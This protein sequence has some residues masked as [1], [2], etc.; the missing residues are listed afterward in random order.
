MAFTAKRKR[1]ILLVGIISLILIGAAAAFYFFYIVP[2]NKEAPATQPVASSEND[3]YN[4]RLKTKEDQVTKLI[5]AGDDASLNKAD[6][7][8]NS[9]V[10]AAEASGS[11]RE[12]VDAGIAKASLLIQTERAQEALDTVLMP[13]EK[14]YGS[15]DE[16]KNEIYASISWAYRVLGDPDTAAEYFNKIPSKGWD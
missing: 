13:L 12:M 3:A 15:N 1:I 7:I 16:Y 9:Q 14:K 8:V 11:D 2:L 4:Q 5:N 6:E 10:A